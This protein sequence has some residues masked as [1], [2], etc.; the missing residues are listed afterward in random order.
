MGTIFAQRGSITFPIKQNAKAIFARA[1]K[2]TLCVTKAAEGSKI[3]RKF[4]KLSPGFEPTIFS[5]DAQM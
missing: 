3:D 2:Q 5:H 1:A 4:F